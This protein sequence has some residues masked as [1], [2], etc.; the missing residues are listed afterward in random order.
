MSDHVLQLI[1]T[2]PDFVPG[3]EARAGARER[4]ARALPHAE[5]ISATVWDAVQFVDPGANLESVRCP[6]CRAELELDWWQE[7]MG[8]AHEQRF[9]ALA[10]TLPCCGAGSS[11]DA[12]DY[13][14]PAGF[15][16]FVLEARNPGVPDLSDR[17]LREL[18]AELG[19][20]L[21]RVVA[22]L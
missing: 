8:R 6:H 15:A 22:L 3:A 17:V 21:R 2:R 1:P 16:R 7:A 10:L 12:L 4:L 9:E 20:S 5:A 11:L 19:C 18:E 14:R 13:D